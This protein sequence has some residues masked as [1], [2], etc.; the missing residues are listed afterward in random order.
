MLKRDFMTTYTTDVIRAQLKDLIPCHK[1][2][3]SYALHY[4]NKS[5]EAYLDKNTLEFTATSDLQ[6]IFVILTKDTRINTLLLEIQ[7]TDLDN[8]STLV[9]S[10][11]MVCEGASECDPAFVSWLKIGQDIVGA[12]LDDYSG[13]TVSINGS[14]NILAISSPF[15]DTEE[16]D[17]G[18]V[19]TYFWNEDHWSIKGSDLVGLLPRE[20][21][22]YSLDLSRDGN[23]LAIANNPD[24]LE[25]A[26]VRIYEWD[27]NLDDW[28]KL[29]SDISTQVAGNGFGKTV[30]L[31]NNG[32][33]VA[34]ASEDNTTTIYSWNGA[35][36]N[37]LG[38]AI[39]GDSSINSL[40]L[41]GSG[42]IL[43]IG[44][45]YDNSIYSNGGMVNMYNY[46]SG[47]W[48]ELGSGI[49]AV[50]DGSQT[51]FSVSLDYDGNTV[52]VGSPLDSSIVASGGSFSAYSFDSNT[53]NWDRIGNIIYGENIEDNLGFCVDISYSGNAVAV[54]SH[55][56]DSLVKDIG[57]VKVYDFD[58][59]N[60]NQRG[61]NIYGSRESKNSGASLAIN[62]DGN[63]VIIG[64]DK[65]EDISNKGITR[66]Y[67]WNME[68]RLL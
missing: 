45:P 33:V 62:N 47:E 66:V 17:T 57:Y 1:Y 49:N 27:T 64:A 11:F 41:N 7:T 40:S 34:I 30:S 39:S 8:D 51:G 36:W 14:G 20:H 38:S 67:A 4:S 31:N 9:H 37:P 54:G 50:S 63:I 21:I 23:V 55:K 15:A 35:S 32:S 26:A 2:R 46:V 42:N 52:V 65:G 28:S 22:G 18:A 16:L 48:Y 68:Y 25:N 61:F 44:Y 56:H 6:N 19:K 12:S 24:A 43:A 13:R 5:Y 53:N 60:W 59:G 58:N 29:G 10:S 3:V